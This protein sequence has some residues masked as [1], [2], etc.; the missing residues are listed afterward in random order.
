MLRVREHTF[1]GGCIVKKFL[2]PLVGLLVFVAGCRVLD[3]LNPFSDKWV[4]SPN[5]VPIEYDRAWAI[6]TSKMPDWELE[7][8]DKDDGEIETLWRTSRQYRIKAQVRLDRVEED[9]KEGVRF[10]LRVLR[11]RPKDIWSPHRSKYDDWVNEDPDTLRQNVLI[12][13]FNYW[14]KDAIR[15]QALK[16]AEKA[17]AE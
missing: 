10:R 8:A 13:R 15:R 12:Q 3:A 9:G 5:Y 1:D 6:I 14:L 4:E 17:A 11:Q 16:N 2:L 7:T